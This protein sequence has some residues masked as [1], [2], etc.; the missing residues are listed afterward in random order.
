MLFLLFAEELQEKELREVTHFLLS[1]NERV[2]AATTFSASAVRG[3]AKVDE[4]LTGWHYDMAVKNSML[5]LLLGV[6]LNSSLPPA[7]PTS[8]SAA[9]PSSVTSPPPKG[10]SAGKTSS[11]PPTA[12]AATPNF[13]VN[14]RSSSSSQQSIG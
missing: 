9:S 8:S 12:V 4:A 6:L 14:Y 3:E 5:D 11:S 10:K 13:L 2:V 7:L 1:D